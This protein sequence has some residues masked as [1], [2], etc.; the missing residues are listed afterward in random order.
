M[1]FVYFRAVV[2]VETLGEI[3]SGEVLEASGD[4]AR[5]NVLYKNKKIEIRSERLGKK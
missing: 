2:P 5:L 3:G 4:A 1:V